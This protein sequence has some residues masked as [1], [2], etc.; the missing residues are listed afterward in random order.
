[1]LKDYA[2]LLIQ[3]VKLLMNL[4]ELAKHVMLATKQQVQHVSLMKILQIQLLIVPKQMMMEFVKDA[5]KVMSSIR[6]G[7]ALKLVIYAL[8]MMKIVDIV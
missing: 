7:N 5:L 3:F 4:L 2:E 1:M 6:L 8:V